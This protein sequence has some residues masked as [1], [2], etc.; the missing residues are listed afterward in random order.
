M[1]KNKKKRHHSYL[2][3]YE[4]VILIQP[5]ANGRWISQSYNRMADGRW[6]LF[7]ESNCDYHICPYDGIFRKCSVCGA[8][9]EDFDLSFCKK[10]YIY[11]DDKE[12]SARIRDC[13]RAG[14]E[15]RYVKP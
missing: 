12:L 5:L 4:T 2:G 3:D 6:F 11:V 9:K 10:R 14:L 7:Y 8:D 1:Y 13:K 15:V